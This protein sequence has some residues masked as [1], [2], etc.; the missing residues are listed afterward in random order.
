MDQGALVELFFFQA[1]DGIR[2]RDVTGVQTSALPIFLQEDAVKSTATSSGEL[3]RVE[4]FGQVAG[5][6][7][8][9]VIRSGLSTLSAPFFHGSLDM[10]HDRS[11]ERRVGKEWRSGMWRSACTVT[12]CVTG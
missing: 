3:R 10:D 9:L 1:E 5:G 7:L 6:S 4:V 2:D 11:E 12:I 8:R